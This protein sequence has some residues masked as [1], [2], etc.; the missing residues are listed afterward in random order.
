LYFSSMTAMHLSRFAEEIIIYNT[1]EF[2]YID[3]DDSFAT[4][5]SIMPQKKNPDIPELLRGKTGKAFGRL[6]AGLSMMK[7]LPQAY[8]KDLQED[9]VLLFE[10]VDEAKLTLFIASRF[11]RNIKFNSRNIDKQLENKFMYAVDIADYLV[12]RGAAFRDAH[13]ITGKLVAYC[14]EKNI[15]PDR[16][17]E[18][19]LKKISPDLSRDILKIF[20]PEKSTAMKKTSGSTSAKSVI[21]QIV[22]GEKLLK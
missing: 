4:G 15:Q 6:M 10:A 22:N 14:L 21:R 19:E 5:S 8:N 11:V 16:L 13:E 1:S 7:A 9:K 20:S 3:I 18:E 17:S 12:G 2:G